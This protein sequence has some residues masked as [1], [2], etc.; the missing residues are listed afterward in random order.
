MH[1]PSV[2]WNTWF[3]SFGVS[4]EKLLKMEECRSII[5]WLVV[6]LESSQ[7]LRTRTAKSIEVGDKLDHINDHRR[8]W[9]TFLGPSS[10]SMCAD[11]DH[12]A[13]FAIASPPHKPSWASRAVCWWPLPTHD[14][15]IIKCKLK[16]ENLHLAYLKEHLK[17]AKFNSAVNRAHLDAINLTH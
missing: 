4:I 7:C 16:F 10:T 5:F 8:R 1:L 11:L 15:L 12:Y 3:S 17:Q 2:L 9:N 13:P 14:K 6:Y